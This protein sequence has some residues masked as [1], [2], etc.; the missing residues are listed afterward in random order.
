MQAKRKVLLIDDDREIQRCLAVRLRAA[1]YDVTVASNGRQGIDAA[2]RQK[3]DVILLDML[4]PVMDGLTTLQELRDAQ[5]GNS[6]PVVA[7]TANVLEQT[8]K[9]AFDLGARYFLE[10]PYESSRLI[11]AV[12]SA[13]ESRTAHAAS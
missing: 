6:I 2:S 4:M 11:H 3:P 5:G 8:R 13:L 9:K 7:L 12:E 10:K 1:G